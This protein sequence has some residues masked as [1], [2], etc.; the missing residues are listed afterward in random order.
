M[1][2]KGTKVRLNNKYVDGKY[3]REREPLTVSSIGKIGHTT[4][5]YFE[6]GGLGAYALDGL[7]E[8]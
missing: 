8:V 4:V 6:E 2:K 3:H 5:A 7:E 1:I